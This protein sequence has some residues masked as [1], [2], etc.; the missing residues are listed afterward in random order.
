MYIRAGKS[1]MRQTVKMLEMMGSLRDALIGVCKC[2][3]CESRK[4]TEN[5]TCAE[6]GHGSVVAIADSEEMKNALN[7]M[8]ELMNDVRDLVSKISANEQ[9]GA[10][11]DFTCS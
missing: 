5:I 7:E 2:S 1:A 10:S 9:Y 3:D 6:C 4:L 11:V 8:S